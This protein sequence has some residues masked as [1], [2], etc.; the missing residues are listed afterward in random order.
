MIDMYHFDVL[1]Q[2]ILSLGIWGIVGCVV[3]L[4][5][6]IWV[7]EK[8][9]RFGNIIVENAMYWIY[10][11]IRYIIPIVIVVELWMR[12]RGYSECNC[13]NTTLVVPAVH[14]SLDDISAICYSAFVYVGGFVR[15]SS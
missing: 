1:R 7:T 15:F 10:R 3:I 12:W 11:L 4:L 8:V 5:V 14:S 13:S 2:Y 6:T 9:F